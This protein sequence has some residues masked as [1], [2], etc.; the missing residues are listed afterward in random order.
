MDVIESAVSTLERVES[1]IL[2]SLYARLF[3][4]F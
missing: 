3:Y 4:D 1:T 2:P